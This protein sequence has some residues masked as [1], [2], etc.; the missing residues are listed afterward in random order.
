MEVDGIQLDF[1][2]ELRDVK[3]FL[4]R[5]A[6]V[7]VNIISAFDEKTMKGSPFTGKPAEPAMLVKV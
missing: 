7:A 6:D 1:L 3:H 4:F 5:L 2:G